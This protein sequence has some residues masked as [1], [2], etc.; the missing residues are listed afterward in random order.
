[1]VGEV[2]VPEE[3]EVEV[4]LEVEETLLGKPVNMV[5]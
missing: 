3:K 1:M 2:E 4:D 5:V